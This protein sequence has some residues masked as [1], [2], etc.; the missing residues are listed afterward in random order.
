[1]YLRREQH[2][3]GLIEVG[4]SDLKETFLPIPDLHDTHDVEAGEDELHVA[5]LGGVT[6]V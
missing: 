3:T 5:S 6:E 2:L 4:G 1:M